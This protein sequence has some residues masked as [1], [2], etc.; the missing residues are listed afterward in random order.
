MHSARGG[1]N[2]GECLVDRPMVHIILGK[3]GLRQYFL[4]GWNRLASPLFE[5]LLLTF[6]GKYT[7]LA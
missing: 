1:S 7:K 2:A 5:A 6:D 4:G 3:T